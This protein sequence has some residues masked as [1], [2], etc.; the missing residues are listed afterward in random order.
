MKMAIDYTSECGFYQFGEPAL[1]RCVSFAALKSKDLAK[2]CKHLVHAHNPEEFATVVVRWAKMGPASEYDLYLTRSVLQL[3][4]TENL[5]DANTFYKLFLESCPIEPQTPLV[6]FTGFLLKTLEREAYPLFKMLREK[7]APAIGRA[8]GAN[9]SFDNYLDRI[10][11]LFYG[12]KPA[13]SGMSSLLE[14]LMR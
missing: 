10:G 9:P 4:C 5:K 6:R 1:H 11:L 12:V 13:G 3:L 14:M 7:Y 8:K 2:A